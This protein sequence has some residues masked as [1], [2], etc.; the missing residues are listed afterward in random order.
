MN[1]VA[2][3]SGLTASGINI[4]FFKGLT[5]MHTRTTTQMAALPVALA[6]AL[7][8]PAA[9]AQVGNTNVLGTLSSTNFTMPSTQV[10][11]QEHPELIRILSWHRTPVVPRRM[12]TASCNAN[13][14]R[15]F[16]ASLTT[17]TSA[18]S[19]ATQG[20]LISGD[21][22]TN[23][24]LSNV[25]SRNFTEC[26]EMAGIVADANC[27]T[28]AALCRRPHTA[29]GASKDLVS[30]L[31]DAGWRDWLTGDVDDDQM[32]LYEW[33]GSATNPVNPIT[34]FTSNTYV[35]S[36]S[37]PKGS[38]GQH[39]HF[40]LAMT[41]THY[42]I[43]LRADTTDGHGADHMLV[44]NRNAT[45][46]NTSIATNRGWLWAC[47]V[48]HTNAH[49]PVA[50][51]SGNFGALCTT[52]QA[53]TTRPAFEAGAV[54][55]RHETQTTNDRATK[56]HDVYSAHNQGVHLAFNGGGTSILPSPDGGFTG[57]SVGSPSPWLPEASRIRL[58]RLDSLGRVNF[59][60]WW[61]SSTTHFLSYPQLA[62]LGNDSQGFPRYLIGWAQM[63]PVNG[64]ALNA[65]RNPS[66]ANSNALATKYFVREIDAS[67]NWKSASMEVTNGWG[68]QDQMVSLDRGRV[69][70]VQR[71]D[72]RWKTT[73]PSATSRDVTLSVYKSNT[74]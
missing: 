26:K 23:G 47:A 15:K 37:A 50:N 29:T 21:V 63:M 39:G 10:T 27:T 17:K 35:V 48:G 32:W 65:I 40:N 6:M 34:W 46:A 69:G 9:S 45:L 53:A 49:R 55:F 52:D 13:G 62:Y 42:G 28:V 33:K 66:P 12:Y 57:V 14:T 54:W 5:T 60:V 18:T 38:L 19:T 51:N 44:V 3:C 25:S 41:G 61:T 58:F 56:I 2:K 74:M 24:A 7:L 72:P 8:A 59:D 31:S 71:P 20:T 22:G 73:L 1:R 67:G 16:F 36:K 30:A 64:N 43:S 68:E 11:A 4:P 70:W